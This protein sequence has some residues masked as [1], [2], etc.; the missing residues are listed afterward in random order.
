M[1]SHLYRADNMYIGCNVYMVAC[2][3]LAGQQVE[4]GGSP[5]GPPVSPG[6]AALPAQPDGGDAQSHGSPGQGHGSPPRTHQAPALPVPT[7][8]AAARL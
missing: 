4:Y 8:A 7:A 5:G 1:T 6:G 3:S 2:C